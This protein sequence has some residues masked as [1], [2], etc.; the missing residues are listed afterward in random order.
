M[1]PVSPK[2][3]RPIV[4]L[5]AAGFL[6]SLFSSC[7]KHS[8]IASRTRVADKYFESGRYAEAELEYKNVQQLDPLDSHAIGQLGIIYFAEGSIGRAAAYLLRAHQLDPNNLPVRLKIG[9]LSLSRSDTK[10]ARDEA[11][12]VLDKDPKN[13]DAP[14]LLADAAVKSNEISD[15]RER[16]NQLQ[17]K[18]GDS[19]PLLV[20]L[21]MLDFKQHD[22]VASEVEIRKAL[23][24]DPKSSAAN[25]ALGSVLWFERDLA[26]ADQA[27]EAASRYAQP[28]SPVHLKYA[29]FKIQ[30]GDPNAARLVLE[31]AVHDAPEFI[32][33]T[34]ILTE[35]ELNLKNFAEAELLVKKALQRDSTNPEAMLLQDR[36]ELSEGKTERAISD[37]EG[38]RANFPGIAP[39]QYFL[40][41]AYLTAGDL[42]RAFKSL[43]QAVAIDPNMT[44]AVLLLARIEIRMGDYRLASQS[45]QQLL[46]KRPGITQA[47]LL[48]GEAFR[49]QGNLD[50]ALEVYRQ[51]ENAQPREP[52]MALLVGEVLLLQNKRD[53]ARDAFNHALEISSTYLPAVEQ[54]INVDLMERNFTTALGRANREIERNPALDQPWLLLAKIY[55]AQKDQAKAETALLKAIALKPES[56]TAYFLLA[57]LYESTNR[58]DKALANLKEVVAKDPKA[59]GA[60]MMMGIIYDSQDDSSAARDAYEKILAIN[61]RFSPALNN[62]AFLYSEKLNQIDK[63]FELAQRARAL[64]PSEPHMAD[65]LGWI[66]YKKGQYPWAVGL[67]QESADKLPNEPEVQYHLGMAHYMMGEEVPAQ[68]ALKRAFL[69]QDG[70][71]GSED[72]KRR[73]AILTLDPSTVAAIDR[74]ALE[75]SLSEHI[76]DPVALSR[77]SALYER[78]G[79]LDKAV[80]EAQAALKLNSANVA[81]M[82]RLLHLY[83][84]RQD[85]Q[86]ALSLAKEVHRLAPDDPDVSDELGRLAYKTGDFQWAY[87][88]LEET[89]RIRPEDSSA[90][91][92]LAN[93]AFGVGKLTEA[94][95]AMHHAEKDGLS[96]PES[97][98]ARR[99]LEMM[100]VLDN[101]E[102]ASQ[103]STSIQSILK[104]DSK[105]APALMAL[106]AYDESRHD[107]GAAKDDY[108]RVLTDF[109][110]ISLANRNLAILYSTDPSKDQKTVIL[111][112]KARES[113]PEDAE[114][115]KALGIA[116]YRQQHYEKAA[117]LLLD[118][119]QRQGNNAESFFYLG[120]SQ[121]KLGNVL[122][123]RKSLQRA[124]DIG[125]GT[126]ESNEARKTLGSGN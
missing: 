6:A 62:L 122:A 58:K 77:L 8:S 100:E 82:L 85:T 22:P 29:Q 3:N 2:M 71:A 10:E 24:L 121:F 83:D 14:L 93:A 64:Q 109:P 15:A 43:S 1:K 90:L 80:S 52:A 39:V 16:L 13:P 102:N 120:M 112:S 23:A 101:P 53:L 9:Q 115:E 104:T 38:L 105:F 32:S 17:S 70:F 33:A 119:T 75:K 12:F 78:D 51:L 108:E 76:D 34:L 54:L 124:L 96:G 19:V 89:V 97:F 118:S 30:T 111:A 114:L 55:F 116:V 5:I 92:D 47:K 57:E 72:A 98:V 95:E 94:E 44:E 26:H 126:P 31:K 91:Y 73:L 65:T 7:S 59:L 20:A 50:G 81:T 74:A 41:Q 107:F 35:I 79:D 48:L 45:L 86:M 67:L 99:F 68:L 69:L 113:Y 125:L 87:S 66:A 110:E 4:A 42:E 27:F 103:K 37:L 84:Q 25:F 21:G 18:S 11:N 117:S 123:S 56:P 46:R 88:L 106:A 40:G 28:L 36:I 60:L 63:G 61:P 49:D